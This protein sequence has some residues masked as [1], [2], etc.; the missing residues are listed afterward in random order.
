MK[1]LIIYAT[2][3]GSVKEVAQLIKKE[4]HGEI[5]V[6]DAKE[7]KVTDIS[8]YD[9]ILIGSSIYFGQIDRRIKSF[10]F[11]HRPEIL[12][13]KVGIFIMAGEPKMDRME[14]QLKDAIPN[15]IYTKAELVTVIGSEVKLKKFSWLVSLILKYGRKIKSSYKTIDMDKIKE[16]AGKFKEEI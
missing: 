8:K 15:D 16:F 7:E 6:V 1:T 14:Q 3:N 5:K 13:R 12:H 2:K 10:I 9:N 4:M 11:L